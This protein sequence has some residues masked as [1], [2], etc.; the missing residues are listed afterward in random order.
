VEVN[1]ADRAN[2]FGRAPIEFFGGHG[3]GEIREFFVQLVDIQQRLRLHVVRRRGFIFA[4]GRAW[5]CSGY[6]CAC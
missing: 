4:L 2:A 5:I 3:A 6:A 1:F